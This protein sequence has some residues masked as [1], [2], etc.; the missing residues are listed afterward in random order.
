MPGNQVS[1]DRRTAIYASTFADS[2]EPV[3]VQLDAIRDYAELAGL[4]VVGQY[5]D[6]RGEK[7]QL[8]RMMEAAT[9][10]DPPFR[11]V[12]VHSLSRISR[13]VDE[14]ERHRA[15]LAAYG[16]E[17]ISVSGPVA[18]TSVS[19]M[20]DVLRSEH[21]QRVRRGMRDAAQ[22]GFYV[23]SNAPYGYR[24]V[25]VW[26]RG[27]RRHKLELDPPASET[28]RW[29]FDLR[30][31]GASASQIAAELNARAARPPAISRWNVKQVRRI[32]G[33]EVYCGTNLAAGQDM[34]NPDR[35]VRVVNA[36]PA[37]VTQQEFDAVQR[38]GTA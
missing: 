9:T 5:V 4:A 21:S 22:Q 17:L 27:I 31:E 29:V 12:L 28:A 23:F 19:S 18:G 34:A 30:L 36:F 20:A 6:L 38:M 11:Q 1:T 15:R 37:I 16:V 26:D 8:L 7:T 35:A 13:W 3:N 33:N 10:P 2:M 14:L 24:K 25:V 32:L